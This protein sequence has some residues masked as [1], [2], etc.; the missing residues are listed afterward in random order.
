M[1]VSRAQRHWH[2]QES[3]QAFEPP[4]SAHPAS[5]AFVRCLLT[6]F[7]ALCQV[8]EFWRGLTA[9][10]IAGDAASFKE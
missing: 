3:Y 2:R 4:Q 5:W 1:D 9:A 10:L 8:I 7:A 6:C